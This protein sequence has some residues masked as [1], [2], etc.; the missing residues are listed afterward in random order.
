MGWMSAVGRRTLL[1]SVEMSAMPLTNSKNCLYMKGRGVPQDYA[2]AY[3]WF[4]LGGPEE[5]T[6]DARAHLTVTQIQETDRLVTE[7]KE[8]HRVSPE[9]AAPL[10]I[11]N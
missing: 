1:P 7:W 4:R 11:E 10:H 9:V 8:R 2:Q 3:F 6:A 5:N